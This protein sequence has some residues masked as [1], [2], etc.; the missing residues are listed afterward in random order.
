MRR[1]S[2]EATLAPSCGRHRLEQWGSTLPVTPRHWPVAMP[3]S[4]VWGANRDRWWASD[5]EREGPGPGSRPFSRSSAV[6]PRRDLPQDDMANDTDSGIMNG[7]R[8]EPGV[9]LAPWLETSSVTRGHVGLR[10][11]SFPRLSEP[12]EIVSAPCAKVDGTNM[13]CRDGGK[14]KS[15]NAPRRLG[16]HRSTR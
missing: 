10:R 1:G 3:R 16:S 12:C 7:E 11:T 13:S 9:S 4:C 5:A 2:R 15:F 8:A 14:S 6:S